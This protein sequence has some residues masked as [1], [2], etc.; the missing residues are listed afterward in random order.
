VAGAA[1]NAARVVASAGASICNR[2][3]M[4]STEVPG[5]NGA[6]PT[7]SQRSRFMKVFRFF[8]SIC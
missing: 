7:P 4:T 1:A 2:R 8:A 6:A 3:D 5:R